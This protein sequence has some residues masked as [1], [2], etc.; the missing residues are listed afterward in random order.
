MKKL[1]A[2]LFT[3][4][5]TF[6]V[7]AADGDLDMSFDGDGRVVTDFQAADVASEVLQL[8]DGKILVAGIVNDSRNGLARYNADGSLDT[9]FGTGG[10]L[11]L[12]H[13]GFAITAIRLQPDGKIVGS[14]SNGE[15]FRLNPNGSLDATLPSD[16]IN[17]R[18]NGLRQIKINGNNFTFRDMVVQPDGKYVFATDTFVTT[19]SF[20]FVFA[21]IRC[22]ANGT[23]DTG[24]GNGG[25]L[26]TNAPRGVAEAIEISPDN[27]IIVA[28]YSFDTPNNQGVTA[29]VL[30]Y[31]L[32]GTPDMTFGTGGKAFT[33]RQNSVADTTRLAV[34]TDGKIAI[35]QNYRDPNFNVFYISKF[36]ANGLLDASFGTN[37]SID[38]AANVY[39]IGFMFKVLFQPDGKIVAFGQ[40]QP[41]PADSNYGMLV[42]R[43]NLNGTPDTTFG[44][45][46]SRVTQFPYVSGSNTVIA[47]SQASSGLIQADGKLLAVGHATFEQCQRQ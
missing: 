23:L 38:R 1:L 36:T 5:F 22:N 17:F 32:D 37:G 45:N 34:H 20:A 12:E 19:P 15:I 13:P 4:V 21:V 24:F 2:I 8:P 3:A 29:A 6:S 27:K 10:K 33:N 30:R 46:G 26:T 28:G 16:N 44:A 35:A 40:G 18:P 7:F 14:T 11:V 25:I 47:I 41:G 39:G 43:Y 31:N 9:T 42:A